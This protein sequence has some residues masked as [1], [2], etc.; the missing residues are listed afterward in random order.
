MSMVYWQLLKLFRYHLI[1]EIHFQDK[2]NSSCRSIVMEQK[3]PN[4]ISGLLKFHLRE[5]SLI[6]SNVMEKL[7]DE[8]EKKNFVS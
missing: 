6:S 5:N 1:K 4:N 3:D 7:K 2:S 8:I